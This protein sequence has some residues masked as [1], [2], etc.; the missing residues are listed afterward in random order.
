MVRPLAVPLVMGPIVIAILGTVA[1][2]CRAGEPDEVPLG[3]LERA[4]R[5]PPEFRSDFGSYKSPL[6]LDDGRAVRDAAASRPRRP[7]G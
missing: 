2:A 1:S 4:F 5:P 7:R 6:A 3:P